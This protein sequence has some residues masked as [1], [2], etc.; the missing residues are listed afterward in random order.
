MQSGWKPP[1]AAVH[2]DILEHAVFVLAGFLCA[3][4]VEIEVI[5]YEQI[6]LAVAVV[7]D[8]S[9]ARA[10]TG[11]ICSHAGF[12]GDIRESAVPIVVIENVFAPVGDEQIVK[13]VVIV[14]ADANSARPAGSK[15]PRLRGDVGECAVTVVLV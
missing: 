1:G 3:A 15:Q 5:R 9:A 11:A 14:I 4:N 8:P 10:P 6:E 7:V 13:A 2:R 12:F